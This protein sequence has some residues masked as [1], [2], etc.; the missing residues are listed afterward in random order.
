[1]SDSTKRRHLRNVNVD[2]D[3]SLIPSD[4]LQSNPWFAVAQYVEYRRC[5]QHPPAIGVEYVEMAQKEHQSE[6]L[7]ACPGELGRPGAV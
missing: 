7:K 6:M 2:S 3:Q 1:M 4:H 5:P